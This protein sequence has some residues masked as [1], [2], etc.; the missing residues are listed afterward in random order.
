MLSVSDAVTLDDMS[1]VPDARSSDE[2][3]PVTNRERER[4]RERDAT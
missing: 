4:E 3:R 2:E 1:T